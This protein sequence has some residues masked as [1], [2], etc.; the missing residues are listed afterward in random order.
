MYFTKFWEK[1]VREH[2][3]SGKNSSAAFREKKPWQLTCEVWPGINK[4]L[5]AIDIL[6]NFKER[7]S[8]IV[9]RMGNRNLMDDAI[10]PGKMA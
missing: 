10:F 9:F 5:E 4:L 8:T 1:P 2:R 6:S 7:Q 3:N